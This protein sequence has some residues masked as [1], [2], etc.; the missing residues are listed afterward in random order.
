MSLKTVRQLMRLGK[1]KNQS[2][3]R[4]SSTDDDEGRYESHLVIKVVK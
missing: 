2:V 4:D 3:S 1:S